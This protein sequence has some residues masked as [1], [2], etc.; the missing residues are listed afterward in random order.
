MKKQNDSNRTTKQN[1]KGK[2]YKSVKLVKGE[3]NN[4]MI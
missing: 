3:I 1:N 4:K 2:G